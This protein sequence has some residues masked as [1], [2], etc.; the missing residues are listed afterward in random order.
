MYQRILRDPLRFPD[1]MHA[2]AKSVITGLLQRDP[3]KRLGNNGAED[4]KNHPFFK[5]YV[6]WHAL[7]RKKI[8]PP[9]KPSVQSAADTSNFDAEFTSEVP[10][11]SV[12]ENSHLSETVQDQFKGFTYN[13]ANEHLSES[14]GY[15][16]AMG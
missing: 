5:N 7:S 13:P 3:N 4:I 9:F 11:D 2:E 15:G 8:Q 6:D 12:V 14:V 1:D 10:L 16:S